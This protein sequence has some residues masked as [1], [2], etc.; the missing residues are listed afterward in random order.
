MNY[1]PRYLGRGSWLSRRDPRLLV[2]GVVCFVFTVIQVWDIRLM[3]CLAVVAF[4]WYR[5]AGIPFAS[6]RRQWLFVTIF[7]TV[8][9]LVNGVITGGSVPRIA[10]A[11]LQVYGRLPVLGTRVSAESLLYAATQLIRF[12]AMA[13]VGFPLAFAMRPSDIGAT[14]ARL[15]IPE[16]FAF[17]VDLTFRFIPTLAVDLQTTIDAQRLRGL[18]LDSRAGGF[19]ARIRRQGPILVPTVV[20]ALVAAEDTIDAMDLRG[21]GTGRR[22]WLVEL[23]FDRLDRIVLAGLV[24][25][26]VAATVAGFTTSSSRVWVPAFMLGG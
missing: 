18:E 8:L 6:V 22:T 3:A 13:A 23:R 4:L 11:D 24:L 20:N 25:M 14:F 17:A 2:L 9:V 16:R 15:G 7:V 10:D 1:A 12:L 21:F 5:S 19:L 26:L